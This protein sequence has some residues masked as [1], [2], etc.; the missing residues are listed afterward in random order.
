MSYLVH[1]FHINVGVGD[2]AIHLLVE[3]KDKQY[4]VIRAVMIDAGDNVN[5]AP[6]NVRTTIENLGSAYV[7]DQ[8]QLKLDAVIITHWDSDHYK[9]LPRILLDDIEE[10]KAKMKEKAHVAGEDPPTDDELIKNVQISFFKYANASGKEPAKTG[11]DNPKTTV[12]C[13][14]WTKAEIKTNKPPTT[15]WPQFGMTDKDGNPLDPLKGIIEPGVEKFISLFQ[16]YTVPR[17]TKKPSP[18]LPEYVKL[19]RVNYGVGL[20]GMEFFF[21]DQ[22]YDPDTMGPFDPPS[23]VNLYRSVD[24]NKD[25]KG[26]PGMYCIAVNMQHMV[27]PA[28][29]EDH[30]AGGEEQKEDIQTVVPTTRRRPRIVLPRPPPIVRL[31]D[32]PSSSTNRTSIAVIVMWPPQTDDAY[33]KMSIY[34][35][36]DSEEEM[37]KE[38]VAWLKAPDKDYASITTVKLSHHGSTTSTPEDLF[39]ATRKN[40]IASAGTEFGHPSTFSL[41]FSLFSLLFFVE[42]HLIEISTLF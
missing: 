4:R 9:G 10:Q 41:L 36:G 42:C 13:P 35:A 20:L 8:N 19:A 32:A 12:Y 3:L 31:I 30:D 34:S 11:R 26:M 17:K 24:G 22:R 39:Y 37:E 14:L 40:M 28:D 15:H 25:K 33:P 7:W 16:A 1:S 5:D 21:G 6:S 27:K 2:A 23:L 29:H 38:L 18:K